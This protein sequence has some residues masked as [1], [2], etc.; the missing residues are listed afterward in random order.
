MVPEIVEYNARS[1]TPECQV[2]MIADF[3]V[4]QAFDADHAAEGRIEELFVR[5]NWAKN[6]S[7]PPIVMAARVMPGIL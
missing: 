4:R 1:A 7:R 2:L 3:R 5:L 6:H